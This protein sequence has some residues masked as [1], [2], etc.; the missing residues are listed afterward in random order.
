[1]GLG[2]K[3]IFLVFLFLLV[4]YSFVTAE[5]EN[6][7]L[8]R[9]ITAPLKDTIGSVI[10]GTNL[11]EVFN[12]D[13]TIDELDEKKGGNR[14]VSVTTVALF[15]LAMAAATGLGALP[16]FFV[17]IDAQW[18]GICNGMAAGVMLAASFDLIQEGRDH[19]SGNWVVMGILSGGIFILLC[20]KVFTH[21][22]FTFP[23]PF[24]I[25]NRI[26]GLL[27]YL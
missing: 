18:E 8:Q 5:S 13:T 12:S 16:F 11:G 25:S 14:R 10:D 17:E 19:G 15:T 26:M 1:M 9:V 20:K 24:S 2:S 27:T 7:T 3:H 22:L 6:N 23:F 21:S 4:Q